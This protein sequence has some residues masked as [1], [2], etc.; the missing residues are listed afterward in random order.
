MAS[1]DQSLHRLCHRVPIRPSCL[2]AA[3][4]SRDNAPIFDRYRFLSVFIGLPLANVEGGTAAESNLAERSVEKFIDM[5]LL[6]PM[7]ENYTRV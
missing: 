1:V 7:Q 6:W 4:R 5:D 3:I 2:A